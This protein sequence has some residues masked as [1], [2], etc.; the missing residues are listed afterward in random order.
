MNFLKKL[1]IASAALVSTAQVTAETFVIVHGAF[2]NAASWQQVSDALKAKGHSVLTVDLP[3]RNAQGANAKA[4]TISQYVDTVRG[5]IEKLNEPV[6][7]VGHSFGG[8]TIS[9]VGLS[10]PEKIKRLVYVAAYIPVSGESMQSLSA[11]D[12]DNGF[13]EK[14]FVVSPDYAFATILDEDRARLFINDGKPEQQKAMADAMLREPLGPIGT[15]VDVAPEKFAAITKAYIRTTM[16]KTV[17]LSIQ[18]M[19]I[20]RT[21][22]KQTSDINTGHSPQISQPKMLADLIIAATR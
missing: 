13:S 10:I 11:G 16:D 6:T 17:S 7:L 2:Q 3:G 4:I 14:S 20:K 9:L 1:A 19:M 5:L 18:N 8:I 21:D 15:K 12:K 22:I